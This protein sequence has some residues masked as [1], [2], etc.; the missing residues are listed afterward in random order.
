[1]KSAIFA[2]GP[3]IYVLYNKLKPSDV[4]VVD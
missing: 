4:L 1:M 3:P 2:T